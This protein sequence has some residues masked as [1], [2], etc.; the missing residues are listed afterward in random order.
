MLFIK[1]GKF[2]LFEWIDLF[3]LLVCLGIS[4][5]P[6]WFELSQ[7]HVELGLPVVDTS[8]CLIVFTTFVD[9]FF[10]ESFLQPSSYLLL[11]GSDVGMN[12]Q[13]SSAGH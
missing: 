5:V 10:A 1:P 4:W 3:R 11:L 12:D 8:D 7:Q 9:L 6:L 13:Y 2:N